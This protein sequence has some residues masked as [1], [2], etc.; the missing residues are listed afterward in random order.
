MI[1]YNDCPHIMLAQKGF[2]L[3]IL[4]LII[5]SNR[6]LWFLLFSLVLN[7]YSRPFWQI[8][9]LCRSNVKVSSYLL[10]SF[11]WQP[12]STPP[13]NF[14]PLDSLSFGDLIHCCKISVR[15]IHLSCWLLPI[16][17]PLYRD[18]RDHHIHGPMDIQTLHEKDLCIYYASALF[19]PHLFNLVLLPH[20]RKLASSR[21]TDGSS[22]NKQQWSMELLQR[23]HHDPF[24]IIYSDR[25]IPFLVVYPRFL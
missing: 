2:W 16:Y 18:I 15:W 1:W 3:W 10:W 8:N 21:Y 25:S 22:S 7:C 4:F 9:S 5:I 6:M 24:F 11:L 23:Q 14:T 13:E 12:A 20:I 17:R 19:A